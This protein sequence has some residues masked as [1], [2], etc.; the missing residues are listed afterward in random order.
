[1]GDI[2]IIESTSNNKIKKWMLLH[3]KKGRDL[4]NQFII[5]EEH[6]IEEALKSNCVDT[7]LYVNSNIFDFDNCIQVSQ[8]VMNK[9]SSNVSNVNYIA[10]CNKQIKPVEKLNRVVV[11]DNIQDP[12]NMGTIIRAALSFG[13]DQIIMSKDCVDIYNEKCIRSTQGALFNISLIKG[14]LVEQI[15]NLKKQG[16]VVVGTSLQE[17]VY[18]DKVKVTDKMAFVFGNEGQGVSKEVLAQTNMNVKIEI[19]NF[20]SLNVAIAS[21]IIMYQFRNI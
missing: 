13:F 14:N 11:L 3:S 16:F 1:M 18:L 12:G 2:M 7:I 4:S 15:D 17:S 20:E 5:E 10:I 6:L 19:S 8:N 21:G 9:L